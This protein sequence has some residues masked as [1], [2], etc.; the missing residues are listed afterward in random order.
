MKALTALAMERFGH[1]DVLFANAGIMPV[2]NLSALEASQ[3]DALIDIN[4]RSVLYVVAAV[5]PEF[6]AQK[7]GQMTITSSVEG[8]RPVPGNAVCCGTKYFIKVMAESF[9]QERKTTFDHS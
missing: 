6:T 7:K 5:L 8:T 4:I 9:R 1:V 2:G 3:W